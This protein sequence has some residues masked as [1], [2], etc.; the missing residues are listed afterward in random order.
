MPPNA[1]LAPSG[2]NVEINCIEIDTD[3]S[4]F[5][6]INLA[7]DS[8]TAH[9]QFT[10]RK[11]RLNNHGVYELSQIETPL[12]LRLLI[13]DTAIN[14]QTEIICERGAQSITTVLHVFGEYSV[15]SKILQCN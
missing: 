4:P 1:I 11:D 14:N 3:D 9:L 8:S 10:T 7:T 13:N 12:T 15:K 2:S 5:W 6:S